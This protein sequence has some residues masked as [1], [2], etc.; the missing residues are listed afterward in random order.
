MDR[1][2]DRRRI[3]KGTKVHKE[4]RR[5]EEKKRDAFELLFICLV[6]NFTTLTNGTLQCSKIHA[7]LSSH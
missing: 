1:Q 3:D 2:R 4:G 5:V 7:R 6:M